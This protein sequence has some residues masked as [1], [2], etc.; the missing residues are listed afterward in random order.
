MQ[1][2]RRPPQR[3]LSRIWAL[4]RLCAAWQRQL[5]RP[6]KATSGK[7]W[8]LQSQDRA[9]LCHTA[10]AALVSLL[11]PADFAAQCHVLAHVLLLASMS[12]I[13]RNCSLAKI[14]QCNPIWHRD[15][16]KVS[17]VSQPDWRTLH[18]PTM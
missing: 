3:V 17:G 2:S 14:F 15:G 12:E 11:Y 16:D 6:R 10:G 7:C 13:S 4:S 5:P 1:A 18:Q 9:S 8:V